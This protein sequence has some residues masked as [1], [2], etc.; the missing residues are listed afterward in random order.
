MKWACL[1][2]FVSVRVAGWFLFPN[3]AED[4][5][6]TARWADVSPLGTPGPTSALWALWLKLGTLAWVHPVLCA[7]ATS[8]AVET[9]GMWA[10]MSMQM[11]LSARL[12]VTALLCSP[13][14]VRL[15]GA[16]MESSLCVGAS[17]MTLRWPRI[18]SFA[19][20]A[21]RPDTALIGLL[22]SP[23]AA[24]VGV[25]AQ[26][27]GCLVAFHAP[28]PETMRSKSLVYGLHHF[29][30]TWS[31]D[32]MNPVTVGYAASIS[33]VMV[34]LAPALVR[35]WRLVAGALAWCVAMWGA[36]TP[37]F[38]WYPAAAR[39]TVAL[40]AIRLKHSRGLMTAAV[41]A[42]LLGYVPEYRWVRQVE[43]A[44]SSFG[45][46]GVRLEHE[47]GSVLLEP[48]GII[49]WIARDVRVIDE[50]G[51]VTPWVARLR[52]SDPGW[53]AKIVRD[54]TPDWI[55]T[56]AALIG[57]GKVAPV[58][59]AGINATL[60][61]GLLGREYAAVLTV[62]SGGRFVVLWRRNAV[63]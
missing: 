38:W 22:R 7:R 16:G 9:L 58:G 59:F 42:V 15:S 28:F 24:L 8:L 10:L 34:L 13:Y 27:A 26:V 37:F 14:F 60:D 23:V 41:V 19:L 2:V 39:A 63:P 12:L 62:P 1:A 47:R 21:L 51:L 5:Y 44:E 56:R 53:W 32:W 46:I 11:A 45:E 49:P 20:G 50:V 25:A 57:P 52:A 54:S 3:L 6:I 36:G 29:A 30:G 43:A 4:A 40:V 31:I 17:L 18:A 55:V 48:V 61:A 35:E 33:V